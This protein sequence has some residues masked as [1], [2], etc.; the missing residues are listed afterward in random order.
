MMEDNEK[1]EYDPFNTDDGVKDYGL[2]EV[3]FEPVRREG[4]SE[5][6]PTPVKS[7]VKRESEKKKNNNNVPVLIGA[8]VLLLIFG[9]GAF[10]YFNYYNQEP[11]A[12]YVPYE[13]EPEI[14]EEVVVE[15]PVDNTPEAV[16]PIPEENKVGSVTVVEGRTGRSYIIVNSL[17]DE[18]NA[19]DYSNMLI[20][21][22]VDAKMIR[23]RRFYKFSVAD[24][25]SYGEA[26]DQIEN[27]KQNYGDQI[28]VLK[29]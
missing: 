24:Y 7:S 5:P 18:D 17:F 27:Y 23:S 3:N 25:E 8:L 22:G 6:V 28:W 2:P 1:N 4:S 13:R 20:S 12:E 9:A 21:K 19:S 15:E 14:V 10:Y 26:A 16:E 11:A 29:Y